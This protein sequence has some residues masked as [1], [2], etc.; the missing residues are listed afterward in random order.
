[1]ASLQSIIPGGF[2]S[3]AV[4]PSAPRDGEPLPAGLYT[5]E[6]TGADI[7]PLKKGNGTGLNLEFTVIDGPHSK[8][9][10][11]SFLCIQHENSQTEQIAQSQL[12][13]ICRAVGIAQL[14]DTDELFQRVLCVRTKIRSAENGYDAKAEVTSYEPAG[15]Q[16]T[17]P[18]APAAAP[19]QT[20]PTPPWQ[21]RA[22]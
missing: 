16:P 6:I 7:K 17:K 13:A 1:M 19:A 10:V 22:A 2:N 8:R 3:A 14:N 15:A 5:V 4:E 12:S 21:K 9:K 11:W 20:K 18:A